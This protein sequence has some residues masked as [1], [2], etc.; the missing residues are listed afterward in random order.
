VGGP[1]RS[2]QGFLIFVLAVSVVLLVLSF[3]ASWPSVLAWVSLAVTLVGLL[4]AAAAEPPTRWPRWQQRSVGVLLVVIVVLAGAR[5]V[6]GAP[7]DRSRPGGRAAATTTAPAATTVP[8]ATGPLTEEDLR[9]ALPRPDEPPAGWRASQ[10]PAGT[11]GL[12][13]DEFCG[14]TPAA[15]TTL[16]V[17]ASYTGGPQG[18]FNAQPSGA[19][20]LYATVGAFPTRA[21]ATQFLAAVEA[22]AGACPSGWSY[23]RAA[24]QPAV[25]AEI[26]QRTRMPLGDEGLRVV[27]GGAP[28]EVDFVY[29]RSGC[30]VGLVAY[31]VQNLPEVR[32]D[33]HV[34]TGFTDPYAKTMA[35]RLRGL[36]AACGP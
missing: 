26:T 9:R 35:R 34:D 14:R 33:E 25:H 2:L 12:G 7:A 28:P 15:D 21:A 17:N 20:N 23:R 6:H 22:A 19:L 31:S 4:P 32:G 29:V 10:P 1:I 8:A 16:E 36:P 11:V 5:L 18:V 13:V 27:V 3:V 30:L 24:G